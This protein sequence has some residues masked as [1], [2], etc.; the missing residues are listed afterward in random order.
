MKVIMT[1]DHPRL[2]PEGTV[3]EVAPGYARNYLLPQ[4]MALPATDHHIR[5]FQLSQ[6][7]A[8]RVEEQQL[9]SA[10]ALADRLAGASC[11]ITVAAGE[12]DRLF[13]SVT[14]ADIT[15]AL[16]KEGFA[17]DRKQVQLEEPIKKLGIYSVS[18]SLAPEVSAQV[19]VWV[20][21]E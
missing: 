4:R 16:T 6:E 5:M 15:E 21:K 14:A 19:K 9:R 20:V 12:E 7:K 2:G 11:T 10:Q 17:V 3:V 1:K 13:G 18:V 8:K